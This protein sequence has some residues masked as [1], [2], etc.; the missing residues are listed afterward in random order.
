MGVC[1]QAYSVVVRNTVIEERMVGGV[2]QYKKLCP[3]R[4]FCTDGFICRIGF[5]NLVD[6]KNFVST[7]VV[8]KMLNTSSGDFVIVD[9]ALGSLPKPDWL[10]FGRY[11][12]IPVV[13]LKGTEQTKIFIPQNEFNSDFEAISIKDLKESYDL[14]DVQD[15]VQHYV[16]KVTGRDFYVGRTEDLSH[17]SVEQMH[18]DRGDAPRMRHGWRESWKRICSLFLKGHISS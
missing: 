3:N 13:C 17:F 16:N 12:E 8:S 2:D 4:T 18:S 1:C 15:N 9:P 10:T 5:M 7:V 6:A 14:V 11:K